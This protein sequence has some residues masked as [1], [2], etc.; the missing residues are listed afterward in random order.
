M[1]SG[2]PSILVP[3]PTA[4]DDHQ[5]RNA[6]ALVGKGAARMLDQ[7]ELTGQRLAAEIVALASDPEAREQMAEAAGRMARP[8]AARVIVDLVLELSRPW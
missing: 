5:R 1:A 7:R 4:T 3:L 8:E 6:A 2:K